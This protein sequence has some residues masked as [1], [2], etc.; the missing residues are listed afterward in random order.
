M[1]RSGRFLFFL[2]IV[3]MV[4]ELIANIVSIVRFSSINAVGMN[5]GSTIAM[6]FGSFFQGGTLMGL[7]KIIEL[8][9]RKR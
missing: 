9:G 6:L 7:G 5:W 4:V 3:V 8:L 1:S 2:G